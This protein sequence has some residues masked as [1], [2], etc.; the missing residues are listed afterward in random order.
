MY[1]TKPTYEPD[2]LTGEKYIKCITDYL[3]LMSYKHE[4]G[5]YLILLKEPVKINKTHYV[6][7][8]NTNN[9][10][11]MGLSPLLTDKGNPRKGGAIIKEFHKMI[12]S[13][14]HINFIK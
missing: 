10:E 3:K 9:P 1:F 2:W 6:A 8:G 5:R 14:D 12:K 13:L 7:W 11:C 4:D